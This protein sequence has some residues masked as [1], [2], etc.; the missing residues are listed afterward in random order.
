LK[1]FGRYFD[2]SKIKLKFH[3]THPEKECRSDFRAVAWFN[4][5]DMTV[6]ILNRALKFDSDTIAGL[7]I[8]EIGHAVDGNLESE[9]REQRADDLAELCT[10][11]RI[12]YAG[13]HKLQTIKSGEWPRPKSLHR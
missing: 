13:E 7:L 2:V 12:F 8:H 1:S 4:P 10:G 3:S 11:H 6:N 9:S 5:N